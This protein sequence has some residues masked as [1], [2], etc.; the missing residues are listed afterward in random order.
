MCAIS[1]KIPIDLL[2][3]KIEELELPATL[4]QSNCKM[5]IKAPFR[6]GKNHNFVSFE[7]S[8]KQEAIIEFLENEIDF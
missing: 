5:F 4:K 6:K 7:A 1:I 8:E 3:S 2:D